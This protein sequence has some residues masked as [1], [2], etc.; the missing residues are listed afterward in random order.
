MQ[1]VDR[2]FRRDLQRHFHPY[3]ARKLRNRGLQRNN[4]AHHDLRCL[5]F[6][7][8]NCP[9]HQHRNFQLET[10]D[11][12]LIVVAEAEKTYRAVHIF[13]CAEGVHVAL[14][15][16]RDL[17]I[18]HHAANVVLLLAGRRAHVFQVFGAQS[19]EVGQLVLVLLHRMPRDEEAENLFLIS[20]PLVLIPIRHIRKLI[21][22]RRRLVVI[23]Y[24][25]ESMLARLRIPLHLLGVL[26]GAVNHRKK[27]RTPAQWIHR[28][29][30]DQ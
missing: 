2:S 12:S 28:A 20:Q 17:H 7:N 1:R 10:L 8:A 16:L 14:L 30:L 26:H 9:L 19:A 23:E 6:F 22:H 15:R 18:A 5:L 4:V 21:I 13:E 3:S 29:A 24:P 25:E 27:L 11:K